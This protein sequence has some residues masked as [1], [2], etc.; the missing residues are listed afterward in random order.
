LLEPISERTQEDTKGLLGSILFLPLSLPRLR[1]PAWL[2]AAK[3]PRSMHRLACF[4]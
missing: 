4:R 3:R 2:E 1:L